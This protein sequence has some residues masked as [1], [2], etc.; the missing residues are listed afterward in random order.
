MSNMSNISNPNMAMTPNTAS[1]TANSG[2]I[3]TVSN[4]A[5]NALGLNRN[6][7]IANQFGTLRNKATD[8]LQSQLGTASN[9]AKKMANQATNAYEDM[10]GEAMNRLGNAQNRGQNLFE[11]IKT[12]AEAA[13][14]TA[15]NTSNLAVATTTDEF[16]KRVDNIKDLH[17]KANG[18]AELLKGQK[19]IRKRIKKLENKVDDLTEIVKERSDKPEI[20]SGAEEIIIQGGKR[21][22]R[23]GRKSKN[24]KKSKKR[25]NRKHNKKSKK[26]KQNKKSKK[27]TKR[28]SRRTMKRKSMRGGRMLEYNYQNL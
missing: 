11:Q 19:N 15:K 1:N 14:Q 26:N 5:K 25:E 23:K 22:T 3:K 20:A 8:F 9:E 4:T 21:K 18:T 16:E 6:T 17:K 10:R 28:S 24:S 13:I 7:P 27:H 2:F 12:G